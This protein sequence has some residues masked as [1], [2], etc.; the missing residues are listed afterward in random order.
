MEISEQTFS[1]YKFEDFNIESFL[2]DLR[3]NLD[4]I[5]W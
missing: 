1:K 3:V 4:A 5:K 2:K